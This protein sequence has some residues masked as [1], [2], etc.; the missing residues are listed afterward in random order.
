M[1]KLMIRSILLI[2]ALVYPGSSQEIAKNRIIVYLSNIALE[3]ADSIAEETYVANFKSK[4]L[5]DF[6]NQQSILK[7]RK[8]FPTFRDKDTTRMSYTGETVKIPNFSRYLTFE[9]SNNQNVDHLI[10]DLKKF[11]GVLLVE[12]DYDDWA[13]LHGDPDLQN[14]YLWFYDNDGSLYYPEHNINTDPTCLPGECPPVVPNYTSTVDA[15]IDA[16]DVWQIWE[17]NQSNPIKVGVIDSG[18]DFGHEDLAGKGFG[19]G[20]Q[21]NAHGTAVAGLIA[22]KVDNNQGG[23]GV[24]KYATI[25]SKRIFDG[26]QYISH[27]LT[28]NKI[29][30]AVDAVYWL[31]TTVG[32]AHFPLQFSKQ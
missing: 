8:A 31:L 23:R 18:V 32:E 11:S 20:R 16:T 27:S 5:N 12:K 21:G 26:T 7:I 10:E 3:S 28:A 25:V 9:F 13:R 2:I 15:D 14:G 4:R 19:D 17:G 30:E 6:L 1:F 22:A 24:D 29:I